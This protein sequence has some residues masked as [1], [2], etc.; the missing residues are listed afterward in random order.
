VGLKDL[1]SIS[2][3]P[4]IGTRPSGRSLPTFRPTSWWSAPIRCG[5]SAY[6]PACPGPRSGRLYRGRGGHGQTGRQVF[7][8]KHH[9]F[10]QTWA[11]GG[12]LSI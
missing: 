12:T 6:A 3:V 11:Y 10:F 8:Y 2:Q 4:L 5:V 1:N 9:K 7:S